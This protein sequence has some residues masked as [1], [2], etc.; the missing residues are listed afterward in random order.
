LAHQLPLF[1]DA[2]ARSG[3]VGD[4]PE[5]ERVLRIVDKLKNNRS[6]VLLLGDSGTGKELVARALH[7]VSPGS[8]GSFVAVNCASLAPTLL[9]SELF[10]HLR[11]SFTGAE[12]TRRGLMEQAHG[13][14]LFLDEIGEFPLE[15]QAKLLRALEEKQIRPVGADRPIPI[16][17]RLIAA[18]NRDLAGEVAGGR[19]RGDLYYRLNVISIRLPT[20]RQRRGD[21]PALAQHFLHLYA[22]RPLSFTR[23]AMNCLTAYDWPGNVRQLENAIQ[24]IAALVSG[25]QISLADLP[26]QIRNAGEESAAEP[27]RLAAAPTQVVP[28]ADAERLAIEH[29]L[30]VTR[31]NIGQ[32]ARALGMGKTTLYRKMKQLGWSARMHSATA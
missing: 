9:E 28:L 30:K 25:S 6:P 7:R 12:S 23:E 4:S 31:G 20:L 5:I 10:G 22:P 3:L 24:R 17:A 19:F 13:G 8:R 2:T 32:A 1:E 11:G 18:T 21:I 27:P 15:L 26:T 14:T 16:E 29:A